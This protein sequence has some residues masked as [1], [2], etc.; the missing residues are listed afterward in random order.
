M[1]I[2]IAF[3]LIKKKLFVQ[4]GWIPINNGIVITLEHHIDCQVALNNE[5]GL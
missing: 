5:I 1:Q 2:L 3:L 4:F